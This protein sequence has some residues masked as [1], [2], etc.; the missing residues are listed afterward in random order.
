MLYCVVTI[1]RATF[2]G[3]VSFVHFLKT[4]IIQKSHGSNMFIIWICFSVFID[5]KTLSLMREEYFYNDHDFIAIDYLT[6]MPIIIS[7]IFVCGTEHFSAN[8]NQN[9]SLKIKWRL[10]C[11]LSICKTCLDWIGYHGKPDITDSRASVKLLQNLHQ[12]FILQQRGALCC[13]GVPHAKLNG[14]ERTL[15]PRFHTVL[16]ADVCLH[17]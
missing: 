13:L 7:L 6:L 14:E 1:K 12:H 9:V 3:A 4:A 15:K 17:L 10:Y 16:Y 2:P 8:I 11:V 5:K